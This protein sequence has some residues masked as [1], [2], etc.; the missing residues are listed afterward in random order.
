M[1][2]HIVNQVI[3]NI[4]SALNSISLRYPHLVVYASDIQISDQFGV[5]LLRKNLEMIMS[6]HGALSSALVVKR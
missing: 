5:A 4:L 2:Y 3:I 6:V 1:A